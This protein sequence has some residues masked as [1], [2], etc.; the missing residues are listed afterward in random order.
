M[1]G[2]R[3]AH[4]GDLGHKLDPQ[5]VSA[6]GPIDILITPVAGGPTLDAKTALEVID[7]LQAKVVIPMHYQTAAMA[8][9]GSRGGGEPPAQPRAGQAAPAGQP[10]APGAATPRGA[11][12]APPARGFA[13]FGT[14]DGFLDLLGPSVKVE[15]GAHEV[16]LAS[17][18]LPAQRTVVV[19]NYE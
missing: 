10:G 11:G 9:M 7:Q 16:T 2:L 12:A 5:Q 14:V 1:P 4:L 17:D 19:M 6:I 13:M 15:R 8:N 3:I 18:K